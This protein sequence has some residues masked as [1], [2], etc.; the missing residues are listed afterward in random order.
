MAAL[1]VNLDVAVGDVIVVLNYP[2]VFDLPI[3][4]EAHGHVVGVL[5]ATDAAVAVSHMG[6]LKRLEVIAASISHCH[7]QVELHS[8]FVALGQEHPVGDSARAGEFL[9]V[10]LVVG[11]HSFIGV[12]D[13][14]GEA[15]DV[16]DGDSRFG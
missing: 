6:L 14:F 3:E 16:R 5:L 10:K 2:F 15:G 9:K 4:R 12:V 11:F 13:E 1:V 7:D 8:F